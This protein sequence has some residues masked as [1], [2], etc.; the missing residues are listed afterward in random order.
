MARVGEGSLRLS[1]RTRPVHQSGT[2]WALTLFLFLI[3]VIAVAAVVAAATMG[4]PTVALVL[5]LVSAAFFAGIIL[6]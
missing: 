5:G 6:C 4:Q 2:R 3:A 1:Q